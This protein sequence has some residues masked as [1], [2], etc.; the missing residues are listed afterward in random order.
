MRCRF[1]I[2]SKLAMVSLIKTSNLSC[3]KE[4]L[5]RLLWHLVHEEILSKTLISFQVGLVCSK[6]LPIPLFK[7]ILHLI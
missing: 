7:G 3:I 4:L 2:I 5:N 6:D 1:L